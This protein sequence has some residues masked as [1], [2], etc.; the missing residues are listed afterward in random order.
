MNYLFT[1]LLLGVIYIGPVSAEVEINV[2]FKP[3]GLS[4]QLAETLSVAS[5]DQLSTRYLGNCKTGESLFRNGTG[6]LY[7]LPLSFTVVGDCRFNVTESNLVDIPYSQ[8]L[9]MCYQT[10]RT[11]LSRSHFLNSTTKKIV[12]SIHV[13]KP[14]VDVWTRELGIELNTKVI[15]GGASVNVLAASFTNEGDYF[16]LDTSTAIKHRDRLSC[17]FNT[18]D[19]S[20]PEI[21]STTLKNFSKQIKNPIVYQSQMLITTNPGKKNQYQQL[22][23]QLKTSPAW[24]QQTTNPGIKTDIKEN[25]YKFFINQQQ[26]L[27]VN[28]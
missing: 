27:N 13:F 22:I 6:E 14:T 2:P 11:D 25:L 17:L 5:N 3:G 9:A 19:T 23:K 15:S 4:G 26:V 24:V 10:K 1:I 16:L 12:I 28:N 18:G 21:N 7:I 20:I 8:S